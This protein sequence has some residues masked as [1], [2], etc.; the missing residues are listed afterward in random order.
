MTILADETDPTF[1]PRPHDLLGSFR[2]WCQDPDLSAVQLLEFLQPSPGQESVNLRV[3]LSD[4]SLHLLK[5]LLES[6]GLK[7]FNDSTIVRLMVLIG[8]A[9]LVTATDDSGLR[10][11]VE[12]V[13]QLQE[14]D[15]RRKLEVSLTKRYEA[16]KAELRGS[17]H[18][19][20]MLV[21]ATFVRDTAAG[22]RLRDMAQDLISD[23]Q[24]EMDNQ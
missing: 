8:M 6:Y 10:G 9:G 23:I 7:D 15:A 19:E 12:V 1:D 17:Q 5:R 22:A 21:E 20:R 11:A 16:L 24:K 14:G 18:L 3:K 4:N 13:R 2:R